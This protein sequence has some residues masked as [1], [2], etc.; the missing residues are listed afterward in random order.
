MLDNRLLFWKSVLC[1]PLL[2][3]VLISLLVSPL[4]LADPPPDPKEQSIPVQLRLIRENMVLMEERLSGQMAN[5][6]SSVDVG[7]G[8]LDNLQISADLLQV[9]SDHI[10]N[11]VTAVDI[12]L[13]HTVCF[14]GGANF[15]VMMGIHDEVGIGWP[16][17]LSAKAI[18]Q[19]EGAIAGGAAVN[20]QF[21]VEVPLYSVESW[22]PLFDNQG[23]EFDDLVA[24]L[25]LPSQSVMPVIAKIY[26]ELMPTPDEAILA[27]ANVTEAATGYDV[28]TGNFGDPDYEA[29]LRPD[30]LLAPIIPDAAI[31]FLE[32]IPG[33]L[34]TALL[35][36]CK[37][38]EDTPIGQALKGRDDVEFLC[39][40]HAGALQQTVL[41]IE[42]VLDSLGWFFDFVD[43]GYLWHPKS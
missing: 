20:G 4:A 34:T 37:A 5:I 11:V 1:R 10:Y 18:F 25:A 43:P 33:A 40:A 24:A 31:A 12:E 27:V 41:F 7:N 38:L 23:G 21:C 8:K 17:V 29:L 39:K 15:E 26:T 42:G 3:G 13:T 35:D 32:G 19:G 30:E 6:Q 2:I 16:N 28:Y 14:E 36:P 22:V 9:T